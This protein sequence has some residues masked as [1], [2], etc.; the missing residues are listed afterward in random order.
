MV[1]C[2]IGHPWTGGLVHPV[3][4]WTRGLVVLVNSGANPVDWWTRAPLDTVVH[5][6]GVEDS[7]EHWWTLVDSNGIVDSGGLWWTCGAW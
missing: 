1:S 5:P 6:A 7:S 4:W 2:T 3:D